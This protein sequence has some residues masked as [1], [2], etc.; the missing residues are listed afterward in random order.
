MG[1]TTTGSASGSA[2][3]DCRRRNSS[4]SLTCACAALT[5]SPGAGCCCFASRQAAAGIA[6]VQ[7]A[8]DAPEF[9]LHLVQLA[10]RDRQEPIGRQRDAFLELQLLFELVAAEAERGLGAWREVGLQV[11]D[12][13]LHGGRR[14]RGRV[15]QVAKDVQIVERRERAGQ[16]CVDELQDT[17]PALEPRLHEDPGALLDVVARRL[18]E[19]R[20]LPELR[21]DAPRAIGLGRVR[22]ERLAG[23]AGPKK[24]GVQLR[25]ALPRPYLFEIEHARLDVRGD[26]GVFDA[27]G[28]WQRAG[29]NLVEPPSEAGQRP[30]M[31][32][33]TRAA[34]VFQQVI[35]Q[36]GPVQG[37]LGRKYLVQ[38]GEV[39]VDKM[40][41]RLRWVHA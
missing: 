29:V 38:I 19:P 10:Q 26:N 13:R 18:D 17:A 37:R 7:A 16:I 2:T 9:F 4:S 3:I 28:R 5:A 41:E 8:R 36:V 32:V 35:V 22:K 39:I 31:G 6:A 34:Q 24:I 27:F 20:H 25:I 21:Y 33:D 14:L 12:V 1:A 30:D 23:E 15:R 40:R 11:V